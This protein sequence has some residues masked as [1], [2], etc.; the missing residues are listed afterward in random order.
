MNFS[1]QSFKDTGNSAAESVPSKAKNKPDHYHVNKAV[2]MTGKT[3]VHLRLYASKRMKN[4]F[5]DVT[6]S[7]NFFS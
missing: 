6:F 3:N 5:P 1:I 7:D 2:L 4:S